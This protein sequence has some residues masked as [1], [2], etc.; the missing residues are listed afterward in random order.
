MYFNN[1]RAGDTV[2]VNKLKATYR[3]AVKHN[4]T[5]IN[6]YVMM[7]ILSDD[8]NWYINRINRL[9]ANESAKKQ[10]L[11]AQL[12]AVEDEM[13]MYALKT[14][15][16]YKAMGSILKASDKANY[17]RALNNIIDHYKSRGKAA[18]AAPYETAVK[19]L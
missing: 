3:N 1:T 13:V 10:A 18:Q 17:K 6:N 9:Q 4:S 14:A 2:W 15:E 12:N 5:A 7:T 19:S 8:V 16:L 11:Q